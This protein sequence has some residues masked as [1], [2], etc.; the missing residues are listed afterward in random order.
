MRQA[1]AALRAYVESGEHDSNKHRGLVESLQRAIREYE[2]RIAALLRDMS[3][4]R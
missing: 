2:D 3:L 4:R 1:E